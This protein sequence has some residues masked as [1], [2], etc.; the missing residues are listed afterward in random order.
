[1]VKTATAF[2]LRRFIDGT[3]MA[4]FKGL[5]TLLMTYDADFIIATQVL[6]AKIHLDTQVWTYKRTINSQLPEVTFR[7]IGRRHNEKQAKIVAMQFQF[8][9]ESKPFQTLNNINQ[10]F[11]IH[12]NNLDFRLKDINLDRYQD[13]RLMI[14][15]YRY[16]CWLFDSSKKVFVRLLLECGW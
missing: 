12:Q 1:M 3:E 10:L 8:S 14:S 13:I 6:G 5:K 2:W 11:V 15:S 4:F 7:F 16:L 9:N